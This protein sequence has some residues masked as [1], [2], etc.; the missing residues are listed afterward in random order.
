M[1]TSPRQS[2]WVGPSAGG[3]LG[4]TVQVQQ[5]TTLAGAQLVQRQAESVVPEHDREPLT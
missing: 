4:Q 3:A 1:G 2:R 5:R